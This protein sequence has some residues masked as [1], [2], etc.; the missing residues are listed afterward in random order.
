MTHLIV[1]SEGD[2]EIGIE[3][4]AHL[5]QQCEHP[6]TL[7][8]SFPSV[9]LMRIFTNNLF[10]TFIKKRVPQDN[11]LELILNIPTDDPNELLS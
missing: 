3:V 1:G 9:G 6:V 5:A 11:K 2:L 10:K 4:A 8:V 7:E